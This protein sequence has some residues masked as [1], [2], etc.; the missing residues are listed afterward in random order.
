MKTVKVN[1]NLDLNGNTITGTYNIVGQYFNNI[2][3]K[4]NYVLNDGDE[5]FY[6][7]EL[8]HNEMDTIKD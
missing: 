6:I 8:N 1:S 2:S 3:K 4:M 7:V 5:N